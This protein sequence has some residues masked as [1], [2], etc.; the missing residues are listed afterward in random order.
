MLIDWLTLRLP[1]DTEE[2]RALL[3][4]LSKD[5]ERCQ[6]M[7]PADDEGVIEVVSEWWPRETKRSDSHQITLGLSGAS[8]SIEGSPARLMG[9]NNVFGS[10][11]PQECARQMIEAVGKSRG[12]ILPTWTAW[13]LTR[14]D[15]TQNYDCGQQVRQALEVLRNTSGGHLK[16]NSTHPDF[17]TWNRPSTF[18]QAKAYHKGIHLA[19]QVKKGRAAASD[20]LIELAQRLM[21]FEVQ[22][23]THFF[24]DEG[25]SIATVTREKAMEIFT[26]IASRIIPVNAEINSDQVLLEALVNALGSRKAR[27]VFS[28]W[29][30]I[31]SV[32]EQGALSSGMARST[33][34]K[35][36]K[37]LL[38]AGLAQADFASRS[39]V[40]FRPR[41][42]T[43]RPV[44]SWEELR[45]AA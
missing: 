21:R 41:Q 4:V 32:G 2:R 1:L 15:C 8:I 39:I 45:R 36:R 13:K 25:L 29:L 33:F 26:R 18:W 40:A 5:M 3:P 20:E 43:A 6:R 12:C 31:K 42:I 14:M 38:G 11:D 30:L 44:D 28:T 22:F 27:S 16:V 34:Y 23:G 17:V 37:A 24:K 19:K 35:H 9:D 10:D 7:K